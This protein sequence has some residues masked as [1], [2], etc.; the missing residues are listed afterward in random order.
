MKALFV[1][2][3]PGKLADDKW[4][5]YEITTFDEWVPRAY[6]GMRKTKRI[7]WPPCKQPNGRGRKFDTWEEAAQFFRDNKSDDVK[8]GERT[9][10]LLE[11]NKRGNKV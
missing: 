7:V 6:S 10:L 11:R 5:L 9:N 2:V 4:T 8:Y 3:R 1:D